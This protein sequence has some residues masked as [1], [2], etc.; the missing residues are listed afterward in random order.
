M[1]H[2]LNNVAWYL[3]RAELYSTLHDAS[4][5]LPIYYILCIINV[6]VVISFVF[7]E[8]DCWAVKSIA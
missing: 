1:S 6:A 2:I 4:T 5:Y 7:D 3:L 8:V